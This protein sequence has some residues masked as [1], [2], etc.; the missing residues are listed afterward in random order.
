MDTV[1]DENVLEEMESIQAY[2]DAK[3][4]SDEAIPFEQAVEEIRRDRY[5]H[6]RPGINARASRKEPPKG[7]SN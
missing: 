6:P 4:S 1:S 5:R 7:D 2:D 3:A